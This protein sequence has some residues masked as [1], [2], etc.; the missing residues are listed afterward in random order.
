MA[1]PYQNSASFPY[2][3]AEIELSQRRLASILGENYTADHPNHAATGNGPRH[4]TEPTE[5]PPV[6][7]PHP[8]DDDEEDE[9]DLEDEGNPDEYDDDED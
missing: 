2:S 7:E 5:Q 6:T 4:P 3:D 1:L 9:D 8:E